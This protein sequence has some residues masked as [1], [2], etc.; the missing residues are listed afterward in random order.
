M[1]PD[2]GQTA[3][4][5]C[6]QGREGEALTVTQESSSCTPGASKAILCRSK[7]FRVVLKRFDSLV[8]GVLLLVARRR[9][10]RHMAGFVYHPLRAQLC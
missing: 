1:Q 2:C 9:T 8:D 3:N 6:R 7:S 4:H 10:I 5:K